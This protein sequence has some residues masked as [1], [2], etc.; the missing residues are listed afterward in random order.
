[1]VSWKK[2]GLGLVVQAQL[3]PS[4]EPIGLLSQ[5]VP[6]PHSTA[7]CYQRNSSVYGDCGRRLKRRE[8]KGKGAEKKMYRS[9]KSIFKMHMQKKKK[10]RNSSIHYKTFPHLTIISRSDTMKKEFLQSLGK[11]QNY[12]IYNPEMKKTVSFVTLPSSSSCD[13]AKT[14]RT[15]GM[16]KCLPPILSNHQTY[17][18]VR[19]FQ[20]TTTFPDHICCLEDSAWPHT[21]P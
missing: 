21:A 9:R 16:V 20:N 4:A 13:G 19:P 1:M 5:F 11:I 8:K 12:K 10:K 2:P 6:F 7:Q 15:G 14:F 17:T 18:N 3:A